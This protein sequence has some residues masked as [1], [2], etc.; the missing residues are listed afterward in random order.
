[1]KNLK[2]VL[3]LVLVVASVLSFATVASAAS[4]T[5]KDSITNTEAVNMLADLGVINGF[6]DG[7]LPPHRNS[8]PRSDG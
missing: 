3:A 2:K 5:D 4:F 8:H 1:M 7:F 6:T